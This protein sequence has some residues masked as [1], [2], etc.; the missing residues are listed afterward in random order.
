MAASAANMSPDM[1]GCQHVRCPN[2]L[3][4]LCGACRAGIC[5]FISA[6]CDIYKLKSLSDWKKMCA[7]ADE[8]AAQRETLGV[9]FL[10]SD[11]HQTRQTV[12]R[13][14]C[15]PCPNLPRTAKGPWFPV[16]S[17]SLHAHA[18]RADQKAVNPKLI[19]VSGGSQKWSR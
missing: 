16:L 6:H 13:T 4:P 11:R 9:R 10:Q 15:D 12:R 2:D 19:P 17:P 14:V 5:D 18:D 7:A 1:P 8:R 3:H